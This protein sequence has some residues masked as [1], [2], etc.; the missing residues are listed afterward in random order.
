[1]VNR[2]IPENSIARGMVK[3]G[4]IKPDGDNYT[5]TEKGKAFARLII[6]GRNSALPSNAAQS[7]AAR[8]PEVK[9]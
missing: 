4:L 5:I 7:L 8:L 1:M 6:T 9:S 2:V 3:K